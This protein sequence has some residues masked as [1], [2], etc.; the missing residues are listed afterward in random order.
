MFLLA[1]SIEAASTVVQKQVVLQF[2]L[3]PSA[4]LPVEYTLPPSRHPMHPPT[5]KRSRQLQSVSEISFFVPPFFRL[6]G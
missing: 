1:L 4:K 6:M 2:T 5:G 3:P